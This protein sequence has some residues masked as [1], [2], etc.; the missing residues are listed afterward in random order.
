MSKPSPKRLKKKKIREKE[1]KK[2]VLSRRVASRASRIEENKERRKLKR[3]EK[4]QKEMGDLSNWADDV[5]MKLNNSTL[6][7]LEKNAKILKALEDEYVE[8]IEKKNLLNKD[9]EDKGLLS[10]SD[11]MNYLHNNL[12]EEQKAAGI[13][14]LVET[15]EYEEENKE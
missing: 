13:E 9:L 10:L 12:V 4:L 7:Q 3:V 1:A 11:K 5:L 2:K 6:C 8:E 15:E 14:G